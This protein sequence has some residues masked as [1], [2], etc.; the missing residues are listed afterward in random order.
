MN[1]LVRGGLGP[2]SLCGNRIYKGHRNIASHHFKSLYSTK[3]VLKKLAI[4]GKASIFLKK[5]SKMIEIFIKA[6]HF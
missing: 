2:K 3:N 4:L 5:S 1:H 6:L